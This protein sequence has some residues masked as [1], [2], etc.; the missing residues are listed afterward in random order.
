MEFPKF[1]LKCLYS[2]KEATTIYKKPKW[3]ALVIYT[4]SL[5]ILLIPI[6]KFVLVLDKD[7]LSNT[8]PHMGESIDEF[9][10]ELDYYGFDFAII[11]G[12]LETTDDTPYYG[13]YGKYTVAF[14]TDYKDIPS[15][16][17]TESLAT[18]NY[19]YFGQKDFYVRYVL[20][21][22][23][24]SRPT[25]Y[26]IYGTYDNAKFDSKALREYSGYD[27]E[28]YLNKAMLELISSVYHSTDKTKTFRWYSI[29]L[30]EEML[31]VLVFGLIILLA[32]KNGKRNYI[33]EKPDG[34]F[35]MMAFSLTPA[36]LASIVGLIYIHMLFVILFAF[37]F[38]SFILLIRI[39]LSSNTKLNDKSILQVRT[40]RKRE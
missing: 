34:I 2:A 21:K 3:Y 19:I 6:L 9:L 31:T 4:I 24:S 8:Y 36:I 20:R 10:S 22:D 28:A 37:N 14:L 35:A 15:V 40:S 38:F 39:Q 32:N 18:D 17:K 27:K 12:R 11:N 30:A 26:N 23:N 16:G 5:F 29:V 7:D 1:L 33:F 13:Y 25:V